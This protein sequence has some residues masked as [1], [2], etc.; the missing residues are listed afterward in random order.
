MKLADERGAAGVEVT[1]PY[2]PE[3][4]SR[5]MATLS[6]KDIRIRRFPSASNKGM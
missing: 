3:R 2:Y 6:K 5:I 1:K 4:M